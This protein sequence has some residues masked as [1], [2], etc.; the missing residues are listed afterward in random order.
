MPAMLLIWWFA[1]CTHSP[2]KRIQETLAKNGVVLFQVS[3]EAE[4]FGRYRTK[5][6]ATPMD[7][8][9][10]R[11]DFRSA[12]DRKANIK[13]N[14]NVY[15]PVPVAVGFLPEG[16]WTLT[17]WEVAGARWTGSSGWLKLSDNERREIGLAEPLVVRAGRVAC[18][19]R[20]GV[21]LK[22]KGFLSSLFTSP[23]IVGN[24][25][26]TFDGAGGACADQA[27]SLAQYIRE[28][29]RV[30]IYL[31]GGREWP[32]AFIE[33][34]SG[35]QL[36]REP[37]DAEAAPRSEGESSDS[38]SRNCPRCS[39]SKRTAGGST[40][41]AKP[42]LTNRSNWRSPSASASSRGPTDESRQS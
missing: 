39:L 4:K 42:A 27:T 19:G 15:I 14:F 7:L 26:L 21:Q 10:L 9:S 25:T 2:F 30:P 18:L 24:I 20:L 28:G 34:I 5:N 22:G 37:E 29:K 38:R 1:G 11:L 12:D 35:G 3:E 6:R 33:A 16:K 23:D 41:A 32:E 8:K 31:G 36:S 13:T 17:R 40:V